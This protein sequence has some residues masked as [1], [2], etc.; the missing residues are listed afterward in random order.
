MLLKFMDGLKE[1][2]HPVDNNGPNLQVGAGEL[3][4]R[5][6]KRLGMLVTSRT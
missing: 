2:D 1:V 4:E 6:S 3:M 5:D